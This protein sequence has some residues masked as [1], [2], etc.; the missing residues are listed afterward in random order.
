MTVRAGGPGNG[1][2]FAVT[3]WD[4]DGTVV[5]FGAA[6]HPED[7]ESMALAEEAV[8][9]WSKVLRTRRVLIAATGSA[10][11]DPTPEVDATCPLVARAG[12]RVRE[13]ADRGD[14]VVVLGQAGRVTDH[15]IGH[16]PEAAVLL[17]SEA[18]VD[19]L[20]HIAP[21]QLSFVVAPGIPIEDVAQMLAA[22]RS[23]FPRLRGQH[24]DEFC[25]AASDRREALRSVAAASDLLLVCGD[26]EEPET[27]ELLGWARPLGC[28][29]RQLTDPARLRPE[30]LGIATATV[31]IVTI[32]S[33]P[34][35]TNAMVEVL[36]GLGPLS[37]A[38]RRV[39]TDLVNAGTPVITPISTPRFA[40]QLNG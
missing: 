30:W 23:R 20:D 36:S 29:T 16:A 34:H 15:L 19:D 4:V 6:A 13:Y 33:S 18:G 1:V 8:E 7:P 31:G 40:A 2:L 27:A 22:L 28:R 21:D 24:P 11:A 39:S 9:T 14:S 3:Y 25:Y 10:C 26:R 12:S 35:L 32:S 5:G 17:E 37:V 38:H